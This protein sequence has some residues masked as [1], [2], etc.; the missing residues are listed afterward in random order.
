MQH[1]NIH[2]SK[3]NKAIHATPNHKCKSD[4][5]VHSMRH[6]LCCWLIRSITVPLTHHTVPLTQHT[7]TLWLTHPFFHKQSHD[8]PDL[9]QASQCLTKSL[10]NIPVSHQIFDKL[11]QCLTKSLTNCPSAS[12]NLWQI[13]PVSHQIFD[14]LSQCLTRS[15]TNCPSVS[16]D[17]D[18]QSQSLTRSFTNCHNSPD[19]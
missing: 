8:S 9:W 14:K 2:R 7:V 19:L 15:L 5:L 13:V 12:P 17:F 3:T 11:S 16:S 10:T 4:S 1:R 6:F 18:K